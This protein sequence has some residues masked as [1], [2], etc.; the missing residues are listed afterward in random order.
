MRGHATHELLDLVLKMTAMAKS[1]N[2]DKTNQKLTEYAK[3]MEK[4]FG[5]VREEQKEKRKRCVLM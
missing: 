1:G 4:Y 2:Y 5:L 3:N